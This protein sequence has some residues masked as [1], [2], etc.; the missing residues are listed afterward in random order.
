MEY[1]LPKFIPYIEKSIKEHWDQDALTDYMGATQQFKD[2]A[3]IIE[4]LHI[5]FEESGIKKGDKIALCGRNSANWG[6][7]FLGILTYGAVA[8]PILHEFKPENVHHIV[9]HSES[10][11]LFVGDVVWPTLSIDE[12]PNLE[13]VIYL[14]DFSLSYSKNDQLTFARENLNKMYGSKYP[15]YFRPEHVHYEEEE[16]GE[17]M[18]MI[19]YTSGSTG[20]SKGVMIPYRALA[21]NLVFAYDVLPLKKGDHM[22][23]ML[24]MAHMYGMAFEFIYEF[25]K[26][27]H[28]FFLTRLPSP[29]IIFQAF[30][31]VKPKAVISVPLIIEKIIK[32][33]VLPKLQT[34]T[35]KVLMKVPILNDKIRQKVCKQMILSLLIGIFHISLAMTINAINVTMQRGFK[36]CLGTW[37]WWLAVV[38][39]VIVAALTFGGVIPQSMMMTAIW[40]VL[41]VA[42][43]GIYLL[44][45]IHRNPLINILAGLYDTY[46][47]AS[48][49]MGDILSYIRLY[50]LGLAGG[51]LGATFN[52]LAMMSV[53]NDLSSAGFGII[54]FLLI[55]LIGHVLNIAMSCLSAFVHP[56]RLS[57][58]EYFKNAGYEGKGTEYKPFKVTEE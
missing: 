32:K 6:I 49:L 5:L 54:G 44:N 47:M 33:S 51:M 40:V 50:A 16:S 25:C 26:G 15:K 29:K 8:V 42:A 56:L 23:S 9:N 43:V 35:M 45:N 37:G 41:G 12:M 30:Q 48:G 28:I 55:I 20:N 57:F 3:R 7:S 22:I 24:P 21:S 10:K 34:P 4:K 52:N 13:G 1:S 2:V 53:D 31:E 17:T 46:N 38:G 27:C 58:V 11:L 36:E 14:P 19:N 39:T 18:A